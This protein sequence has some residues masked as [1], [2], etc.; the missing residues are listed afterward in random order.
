VK[1]A[2]LATC[3]DFVPTPE[4]ASNDKIQCNWDFLLFALDEV[5]GY[6]EESI[7]VT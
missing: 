4:S 5:R 7:V 3:A 1:H 2:C 6:E